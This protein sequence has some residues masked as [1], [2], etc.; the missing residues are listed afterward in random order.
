MLVSRLCHSSPLRKPFFPTRP[1]S[2]PHPAH[3]GP[4]LS[5]N[6]LHSRLYLLHR[7]SRCHPCLNPSRSLSLL[8]CVCPPGFGS[9]VPLTGFPTL[10][11]Y[12]SSPPS[13]LSNRR[14]F[15]VLR[16]RRQRVCCVGFNVSSAFPRVSSRKTTL[17]SRAAAA[18]PELQ[19][20]LTRTRFNLPPPK[21]ARNVE[22]DPPAPVV[23]TWLRWI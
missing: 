11:Q 12:L 4:L 6:L 23:L 20:S 10:L 5:I 9:P 19:L 3:P 1:A 15:F 21:K 7:V 2:A 18:L 22:Y 14:S 16:H 17:K 13:S 8:F